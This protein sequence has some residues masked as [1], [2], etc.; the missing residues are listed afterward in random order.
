MIKE[1]IKG[2]IN[3]FFKN[4]NIN[5]SLKV[6]EINISNFKNFDLEI[7]CFFKIIKKYPTFLK[8]FTNENL[9]AFINKNKFNDIISNL[10]IVNRGFLNIELSNDCFYYLLKNSNNYLNSKQNNKTVFIEMVS[11]NPTGRLHIGHIRNAVVSKII[12]NIYE[13]LGW[14][15]YLSY[16]VNDYGVQIKQLTNSVVNYY[17]RLNGEEIDINNAHYKTKDVEEVANN[18][19]KFKNKLD[20]LKPSDF[21][22]IQNYSVD[23][24][25]KKNDKILQ[26]LNIKDINYYYEKK[27]TIERHK[28]I[29]NYLYELLGKDYFE[30][31]SKALYLRVDKIYDNEKRVIQKTNKEIT[32]F[33]PDIIY[34][35]KKWN[36]KYDKYISVWGADHHGYV[37]RI[38]SAIHIYDLNF[39]ITDWDFVLTQL[40]KIKENN[41]TSNLSKRSNNL[42]TLEQI[43]KDISIKQLYFYLSEKSPNNSYIIDLTE[44]KNNKFD[45]F[46]YINYTY[47]RF[48]KILNK[49]EYSKGLRKYKEDYTFNI[50]ERKIVLNTLRINLILKSACLKNDPSIIIS[51]LHEFCKIA[52]KYYETN[53]INNLN[54]LNVQ[55]IKLNIAGLI[56]DIILMFMKICN[57]NL[58]KI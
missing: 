1:K 40:V 39:K 23:F 29:I 36:D 49:S 33:A 10:E 45:N 43:T 31:D 54:D 30:I 24:F 46:Y 19:F 13:A 28:N 2:I 18:L 42:I 6:E 50:L 57:I 37:K 21:L 25:N 53:N 48:L 17:S 41:L 3:L 12:S 55:I 8:I 4:N 7:K 47:F 9:Q 16:Y 34:H 52:S 56:K 22:F 14:K 5:Y 35:C 44:I 27:D 11:A 32:Y 15:T 38:K 26:E 58:D 20:V 51:T